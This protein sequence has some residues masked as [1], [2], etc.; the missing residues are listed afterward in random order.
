[1]TLNIN[2]LKE[3]LTISDN[4]YFNSQLFYFNIQS[5]YSN[6]EMVEITRRF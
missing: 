6:L 4:N 2:D 3:L 5:F 1:M